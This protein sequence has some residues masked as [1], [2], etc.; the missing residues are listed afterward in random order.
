MVPRATPSQ[1]RG[2]G[3]KGFLGIL[4]AVQRNERRHS[5]HGRRDCPAH[6]KTA[7]PHLRPDQRAVASQATHDNYTGL[8]SPNPKWGFGRLSVAAVREMMTVLDSASP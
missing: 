5:L 3:P 2:P 4:L 6:A 1:R 7:D 8:Q